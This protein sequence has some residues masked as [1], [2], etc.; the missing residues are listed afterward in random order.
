MLRHREDRIFR[1]SKDGRNN[2]KAHS[3]THHQRVSL[4]KANAVSSKESTNIPTEQNS[5]N[6]I[7]EYQNTPDDGN[8]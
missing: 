5:L 6:L 7:P 3:K 1:D 2:S 8:N 4:V